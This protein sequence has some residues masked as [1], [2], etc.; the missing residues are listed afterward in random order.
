[1]AD[2]DDNGLIRQPHGGALRP[3]TMGNG[4]NAARSPWKSTRKF[5]MELLRD[6]VPQAIAVLVNGLSSADERVAA[7]SAEQVLN[8]V[9]GRPGLYSQV[10]DADGPDT[11][12]LSHLTEA[13]RDE[14]AAALAI[15]ARLTGLPIGAEPVTVRQPGTAGRQGLYGRRK[16][17]PLSS[18]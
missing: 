14:L 15:I 18:F 10:N 4:A 12:D 9:L 1:M 2:S 13:E 6:A 7:V 5:A 16:F 8:R 17:S 3:F 11:V